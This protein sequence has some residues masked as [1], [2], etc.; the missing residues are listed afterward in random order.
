M[1]FLFCFVLFLTSFPQCLNGSI[2]FQE[3]EVQKQNSF[4]T[5]IVEFSLYFVTMIFSIQKSS[6][7]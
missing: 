1:S 4:E 7:M 2:R 3:N 6:T 5:E